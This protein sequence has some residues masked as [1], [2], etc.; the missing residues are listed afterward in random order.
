MVGKYTEYKKRR[1]IRLQQRIQELEKANQ[2]LQIEI[3]SLRYIIQKLE[4]E[5]YYLTNHHPKC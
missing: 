5:N 1:L 2:E 3:G 4:T